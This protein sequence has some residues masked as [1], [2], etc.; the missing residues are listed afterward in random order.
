MIKNFL[1]LICC[2]LIAAISW[3]FYHYLGKWVVSFFL[4]II[5]LT[6]IFS[7]IKSKFSNKI[8]VD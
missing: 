6:L 3:V 7:P 1:I 8:K 4:T 5:F 2:V